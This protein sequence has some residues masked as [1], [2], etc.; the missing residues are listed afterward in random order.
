M[1]ICKCGHA[2]SLH[3]AE[4]YVYPGSPA[5]SGWGDGCK[6]LEFK[7]ESQLDKV[8]RKLTDAGCKE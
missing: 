6:C 1:T 2:S 4:E 8:K 5:C 3:Y 7:P